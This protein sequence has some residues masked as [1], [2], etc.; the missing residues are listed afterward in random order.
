MTATKTKPRVTSLAPQF[1]VDDRPL[2]HLLPE[3]RFHI[4]RAVGGVL[5]DRSAGRA[6]APPEGSAQERRRAATPAANEHL[7]AAA[8]VEGIEGFYAQCTA[9]GATIIS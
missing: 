8:G 7:D 9:N 5:R 4:R 3:A 2:D 6:G 1:L